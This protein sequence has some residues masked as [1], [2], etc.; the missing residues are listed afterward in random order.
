MFERR[1]L[2]RLTVYVL[3]ASALLTIA[4]FGVGGADVG[5]GALVGA[6]FGSLNWMGMRWL[7]QRLMTANEKG[8]A[9]W[10]AM[11]VAKMALTLGATWLI[12]A[13]GVVEPLG[14]MIGLS[15]LVLGLLAGAFHLAYA[16][17][18]SE[19]TTEEG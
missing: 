9:V 16:G 5:L 19:Q 2:Q 12:L 8:R 18:A 10:G 4:A 1:T 13:T 6:A 17:T 7:A 11:L 3:G 14:F 15:G